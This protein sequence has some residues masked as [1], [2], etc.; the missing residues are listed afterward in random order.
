MERDVCEADGFTGGDCEGLDKPP[1]L[2][3]GTPG[4]DGKTLSVGIPAH[5][6]PEGWI[7]CR[8]GCEQMLL[9]G[10]GVDPY[11]SVPPTEAGRRAA[12]VLE[13]AR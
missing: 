8:C 4:P 13:G 12:W 2:F 11:T 7:V 1:V 9:G 5:G 3:D 6:W 10:C